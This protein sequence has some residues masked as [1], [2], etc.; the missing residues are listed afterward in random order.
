MK[1]VK[2]V[3]VNENAKEIAEICETVQDILNK[4]NGVKITCKEAVAT[5]A[6]QFL[7][8]AIKKLGE[9]KE[10][11]AEV[12]L[13]LFEL[14]EIGIAHQTMEDDENDGNFVP[15]LMPGVAFKIESKDDDSYDED[16]E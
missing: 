2:M 5:V 16:E 7:L 14:I 13:N 10:K 12:S 11:D 15:F 9:M 6:Y 4:E 1:E 8:T 3:S